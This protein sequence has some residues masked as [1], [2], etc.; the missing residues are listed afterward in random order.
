M[1]IGMLIMMRRIGQ[2]SGSKKR[3]RREEDKD[4]IEQSEKK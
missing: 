2:I 1:T 3:Q 4:E